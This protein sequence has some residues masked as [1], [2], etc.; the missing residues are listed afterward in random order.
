MVPPSSY[1][2][3]GDPQA[4]RAHA[5]QVRQLAAGVA[6]YSRV[7]NTLASRANAL[8]GGS[9]TGEDRRMMSLLRT[10]GHQNSNAS[11]NMVV[12]AS[13][14]E[15]LAAQWEEEAR[16]EAEEARKAREK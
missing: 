1:P 10:F 9:A 11:Q 2:P 6:E 15:R 5:K 13:A 8:L 4:L 14:M 16:Q 3:R 12:A 7:G